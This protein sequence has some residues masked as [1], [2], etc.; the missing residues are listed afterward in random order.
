MDLA[1]MRNEYTR[2]GLIKEELEDNPFLQFEM[3]FKQ[4]KEAN[5]HEINAMT[6]TTVA[7][8]GQP[9]ARTVLLKY[10]DQRGLVFFTNYESRKAKHIAQNPRV[11]LLFPWLELERQ[12]HITGKAEKIST[13]ESLKYFLSRPKG[14]QIG[15]WVSNQSSVITSRQLLMAKFEELKQKFKDQEVP[16]P[17]FWGGFRVKPDSIEFWQGRQYRLHDRFLYALENGDW[18]IKRLAP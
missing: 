2:S 11:S 10:F 8:N 3:W 4:A 13:A 15:A 5:L 16:I 18:E 7:E 6:L 1:E 9:F 17:S 12:V 14:S